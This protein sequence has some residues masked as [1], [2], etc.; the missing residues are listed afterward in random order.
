MNNTNN[1]TYEQEVKKT[2]KTSEPSFVDGKYFDQ[3]I[4]SKQALK[5][6]EEDIKL[7]NLEKQFSVGIDEFDTLDYVAITGDITSFQGNLQLSI[8]R[9]RKEIGCTIAHDIPVVIFA[10]AVIIAKIRIV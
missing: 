8:K 7:K 5:S 9:A 4:D 6:L 1:A 2:Y 10:H 3:A